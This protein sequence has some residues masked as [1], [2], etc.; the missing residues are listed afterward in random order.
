VA[1]LKIGFLFYVGW[2]KPRKRR[3]QQNHIVRRVSLRSTHPTFEL[4]EKTEQ[5]TQ[6]MIRLTKVVASLTFVQEELQLVVHPKTFFS[7]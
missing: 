2:V 4:N 5:Q 1:P 3:T 6:Q 7:L